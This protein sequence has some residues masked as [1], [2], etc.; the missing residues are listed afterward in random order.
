MD[1]VLAETSAAQIAATV[2]QQDVIAAVQNVRHEEYQYLDLVQEIL[3]TGEHRP[4]RYV[5]TP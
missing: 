2:K 1:S 5:H 3:E 4:D